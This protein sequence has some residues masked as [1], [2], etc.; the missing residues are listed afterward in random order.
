VPEGT[1][2]E[3]DKAVWQKDKEDGKVISLQTLRGIA[4][5]I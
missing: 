4:Y 5:E 2:G 3:V 1:L